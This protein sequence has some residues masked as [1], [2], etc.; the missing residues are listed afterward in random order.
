MSDLLSNVE[1]LLERADKFDSLTP[2]QKAG[3]RAQLTKLLGKVKEPEILTIL[4]ELQDEV[5]KGE[6]KA[7]SKATVED[8][9][10]EF[11]LYKSKD[12]KQRGAYKAKVKRMLNTARASGDKP[13]L[14]Q[15]LADLEAKA[16][17]LERQETRENVLRLAKK[18]KAKK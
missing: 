1:S 7:K 6:A 4:Q 9:E 3:F 16:V 12:K 10:A 17:N 2:G 18:R 15:R 13:E 14:V 5:G 11:P 8:V